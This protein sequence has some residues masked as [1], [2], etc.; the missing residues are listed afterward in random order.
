M[1]QDS[2]QPLQYQKPVFFII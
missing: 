2:G 1:S